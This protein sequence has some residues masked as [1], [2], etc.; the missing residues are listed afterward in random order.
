MM[1]RLAIEDAATQ[2]FRKYEGLGKVS[3]LIPLDCIS[4]SPAVLVTR[5]L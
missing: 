1:S 4:A 5:P 2:Q 3:L